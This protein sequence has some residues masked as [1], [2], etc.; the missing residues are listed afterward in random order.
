MRGTETPTTVAASGAFVPG[1]GSLSLTG[2]VNPVIVAVV[3]VIALISL[4][5]FVNVMTAGAMKRDVY[6]RTKATLLAASVPLLLIFGG[7]LTIRVFEYL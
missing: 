7:A 6:A 2:Q 4:L 5:A 3:V 1:D